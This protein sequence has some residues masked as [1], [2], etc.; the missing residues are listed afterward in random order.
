[1]PVEVEQGL[2]PLDTLDP[3]QVVWASRKEPFCF[4]GEE[5]VFL[6]RTERAAESLRSLLLYTPHA[7]ETGCSLWYLDLI[8]FNVGISR[9]SIC[10][11]FFIQHLIVKMDIILSN[12]VLL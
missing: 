1:M 10:Y 4:G 11:L 9:N 12:N 7:W 6:V 8:Q 5:E 2:L 3:L